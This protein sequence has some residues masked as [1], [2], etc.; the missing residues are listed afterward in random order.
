LRIDENFI[1]YYYVLHDDLSCANRSAVAAVVSSYH[2]VAA[3][4]Y[5]IEDVPDYCPMGLSEVR[6]IS[7]RDD[8]GVTTT[9]IFL[10]F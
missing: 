9:T 5:L 8:G 3:G 2:G 10:L 4:G 1:L 6:N 7:F